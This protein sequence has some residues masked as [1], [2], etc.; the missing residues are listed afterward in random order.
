MSSAEWMGTRLD[1]WRIED[2]ADVR[3]CARN[4]SSQQ[5]VALIQ[6]SL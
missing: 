1:S 5:T 4:V 3:K 6:H 2:L